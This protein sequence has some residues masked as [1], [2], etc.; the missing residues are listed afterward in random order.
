MTIQPIPNFMAE[1]VMAPHD[2]MRRIVQSGRTI[3]S[4]FATSEPT[5]FYD[6][7]WD[8]IQNEDITDLDI[9]QSL[10]MRPHRI[11]VGDAMRSRGLFDGMAESK[12]GWLSGLA[13]KANLITRKVEGLNRLAAHYEELRE[14]RIRFTSP[15]IGATVNMIIPDN[16]MT[17]LAFPHLA[18]RN[19][20]RMGITDMQS[21]HFPEAVEPMGYPEGKPVIDAFLCVLTPPDEHG[22]MSHGAAN[23]ANGEILDRI[24]SEC[25]VDL[26]VYVNPRYPFTRGYGDAPNTVHVDRFRDLARRGRLVVVE[27][28]SPVPCLPKD[29]LSNPS[30][31][32][33]AIAE[34]VVNHIEMHAQATHG[35]A[36]QVGFGG[37]GVLAIR[38]LKDSSWRGRSYT[39]MLEPYTLDLFDAG[40]IEGSHFVEKDGRRSQ[41]D[42]KMVATFTIG[43]EGGNFY[44][45]LHDNPAVVLA[46]ACRVVIPEAFYYG[47]GINNCLAVD[48]QGHVSSGGRH[49]NHHSGIGGGA[50]IWRGLARGGIAYLCLKSTHRGLDGQRH[51]SIMPFLPQGT[52]ISHVG[53]DL[54]G[55][56]EGA[57]FYLVTE[58]GV[59]RMS[60]SSQS[61]FIRSIISVAHPDHREELW[62]AAWDAFRVSPTRA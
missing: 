22:E 5:P 60:G 20:T 43:E 9:R 7:L 23:G 15:F 1:C 14:R 3:A 52:P 18:G 40:K 10:F 30:K 39:E 45:R 27:D 29:S 38:A 11:C 16:P 42:G 33:L 36:I 6:V 48:F 32:E 12:S 56:R 59:A 55:G 17:R 53:P 13:R 24:L 34:H 25:N 28:E 61:E 21:V 62:S 47:L 26:L 41:L 2:A 31:Q 50:Q 57:R 8:Y 4:G 46:P 51:S 49:Q 19:T 35:R 44:E 37:T 58:H 54:M